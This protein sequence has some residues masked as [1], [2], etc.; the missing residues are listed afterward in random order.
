[1]S[2]DL[3]PLG[4][5]DF[6]KIRSVSERIS[7]PR[8]ERDSQIVDFPDPGLPEIPIKNLVDL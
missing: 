3:D 8:L 6:S 5:L 7:K 4:D 1:M 2:W